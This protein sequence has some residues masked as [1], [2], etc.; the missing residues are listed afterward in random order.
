MKTKKG[1]TQQLN[2]EGTEANAFQTTVQFSKERG[3]RMSR[4]RRRR[5]FTSL[6]KDTN[7]AAHLSDAWLCSRCSLKASHGVAATAPRRV[8]I[9]LTIDQDFGQETARIHCEAV[10][11]R[12][13]GPSGYLAGASLDRSFCLWSSEA[14]NR[15]PYSRTIL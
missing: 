10:F 2:N 13:E 3:S 1:A 5:I 6:C 15:A 7:Q 11:G 9:D 8:A 14:S 4:A 12:T